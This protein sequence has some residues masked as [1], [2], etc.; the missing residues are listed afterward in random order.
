MERDIDRKLKI[1][2]EE[3]MKVLMARGRKPSI[4]L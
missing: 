1:R 2:E 3:N 4:M